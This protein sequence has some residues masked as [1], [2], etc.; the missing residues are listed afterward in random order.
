MCSNSGSCPDCWGCLC[1]LGLLKR[2]WLGLDRGSGFG[3]SA[4]RFRRSGWRGLG[5]FR[6]Q[7]VDVLF[8]SRQFFLV[9]SVL[10][11]ELQDFLLERIDF[12]LCTGLK[13]RC[14]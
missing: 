14:R 7:P 6:D 10:L 12:G 1:R 4:R 8:Q 13:H 2:L 3:L 5:W 11:P 9:C